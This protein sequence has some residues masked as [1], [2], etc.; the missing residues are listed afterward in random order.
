[1]A[2][3]VVR[4]WKNRLL[5]GTF[6]SPFN[7]ITRHCGHIATHTGQLHKVQGFVDSAVK[8]GAELVYY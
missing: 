3:W 1:M 6:D 4:A 2:L 5:S 8:D 7:N